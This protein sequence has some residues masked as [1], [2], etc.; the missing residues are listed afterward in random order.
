MLHLVQSV[1]SS[2]ELTITAVPASS[3]EGTFDCHRS[4]METMVQSQSFKYQWI[5][6]GNEMYSAQQ[7]S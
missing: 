3:D 5:V 7:L 1:K 2:P 6:H 4:F